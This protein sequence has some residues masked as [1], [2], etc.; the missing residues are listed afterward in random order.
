MSGR[1]GNRAF[2][3]RCSTGGAVPGCS[4]RPAANDVTRI[5]ESEM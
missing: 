5:A 2:G 3:R 4:S 1:F